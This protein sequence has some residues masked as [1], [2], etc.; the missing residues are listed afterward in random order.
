M[1]LSSIKF[2]HITFTDATELLGICFCGG[3]NESGH[4][5]PIYLKDYFKF[6]GTAWKS[7]EFAIVLEDVL[8]GLEVSKFH[9]VYSYLFYW[10]VW[11]VNLTQ[12]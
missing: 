8:P 12:D 1:I 4:H 2:N 3:S 10:L 5:K 7:L 9:A 6:S 11:C